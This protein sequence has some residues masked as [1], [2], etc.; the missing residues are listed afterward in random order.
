MSKRSFLAIVLL[1]ILAA[2]LGVGLLLK[3]VPPAYERAGEAVRDDAARQAALARFDADVVNHVANVLLDKSGSTRLDITLTEEMVNARL[4]L[5]LE[6]AA[7]NRE[8]VPSAL[9]GLR[10]AFEPGRVVVAT[11]LGRGAA[12][13]IVSQDLAMTATEDGRLRVDAG[14]LRAGRLPVP[15]F[16]SEEVRTALEALVDSPEEAEEDTTPADLWRAALGA[17]GGEPV[18]LGR[19]KKQIRLERITIE[20]GVMR[21]EGR[22]AAGGR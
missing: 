6:E 12:S 22:R 17:L 10:V 19:G 1:A 8:A 14:D 4:G 16:V 15:G 5:W 11:R 2:V 3:S 13:V 7:R 21:V 20:R 18:P 9:K